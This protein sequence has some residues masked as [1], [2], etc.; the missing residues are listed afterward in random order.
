MESSPTP[1]TPLLRLT[2]KPLPPTPVTLALDC[3]LVTLLE[4]VLGQLMVLE[5][6][7]ELLQLVKVFTIY[8][9]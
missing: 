5:Y 6:G 3:Q 1:L 2:T 8:I 9:H 7:V 4:V